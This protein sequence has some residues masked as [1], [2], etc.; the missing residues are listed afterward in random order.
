MRDRERYDPVFVPRRDEHRGR[1]GERPLVRL[2][3]LNSPGLH[4]ARQPQPEP[5]EIDRHLVE[6]TDEE[7]HRGEQQQ[8]V[9]NS[10]Q[11][12]KRGPMRHSG[13]P[14]VHRGRA[15]DSRGSS[16]K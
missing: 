3:A 16:G 12:L 1:S 14:A 9:L 11:K 2:S 8:L 15:V 5:D 13:C 4:T 7:E 10:R 6:R